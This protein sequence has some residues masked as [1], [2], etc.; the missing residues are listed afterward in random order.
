[1]NC[2]L[3]VPSNSHHDSRLPGGGRFGDRGGQ[4]PFAGAEVAPGIHHLELRTFDDAAIASRF[5]GYLSGLDLGRVRGLIL[6]VRANSGGGGSG[7]TA[8]RS[9]AMVRATSGTDSIRTG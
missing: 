5:V 1:M 3:P 7:K 8:I 2:G 4:A 6:D 9:L